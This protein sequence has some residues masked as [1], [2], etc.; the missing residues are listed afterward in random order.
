M[1]NTVSTFFKHSTD[2]DA[3]IPT[4]YWGHEEGC[5]QLKA[6]EWCFQVPPSLKQCRGAQHLEML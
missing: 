2:K 4:A 6:A 1:L 5:S 3:Y